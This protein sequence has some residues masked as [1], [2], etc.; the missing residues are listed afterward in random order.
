MKHV[1]IRK[2]PDSSEESSK[3]CYNCG[4]SINKESNQYYAYCG[5]KTLILFLFSLILKSNF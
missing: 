3:Y 4:T 2:D 5:A 1:S